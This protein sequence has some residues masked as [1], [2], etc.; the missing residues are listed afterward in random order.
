MGPIHPSIKPCGTELYSHVP[1]LL[2]DSSYLAIFPVCLP[3]P[4]ICFQWAP[5][6]CV[7]AHWEHR[8]QPLYP[9]EFDLQSQ[10]YPIVALRVA[11]YE[12]HNFDLHIRQ[13]F[14]VIGT[15]MPAHILS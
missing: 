1:Y 4:A 12:I 10:G 15:E 13:T 6:F 8:P 5:V 14:V 7:Q 9:V 11:E 2:G 3:V